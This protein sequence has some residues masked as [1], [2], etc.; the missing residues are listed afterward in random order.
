MVDVLME[1]IEGAPISARLHEGNQRVLQKDTTQLSGTGIV[2]KSSYVVMVARSTTAA[3][4]HTIAMVTDGIKASWAIDRIQNVVGTY[5]RYHDD[6]SSSTA[7]SYFSDLGEGN[8]HGGPV[9]NDLIGELFDYISVEPGLG[10]SVAGDIFS[11]IQVSGDGGS[12]GLAVVHNQTAAVVSLLVVPGK[13]VLEPV[14]HL[15][16]SVVAAVGNAIATVVVGADNKLTRSVESGSAA[17]GKPVLTEFD[18]WL[19]MLIL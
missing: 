9:A 14:Q 2:G 5:S 16:D 1:G 6:S 12:D 7:C 11:H 8:V 17:S 19:I 15:P 13:V 4:Q 18:E 3:G 10:G